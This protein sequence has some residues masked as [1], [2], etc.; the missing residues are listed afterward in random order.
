MNNNFSIDITFE[1]VMLSL[2]NIANDGRIKTGHIK[3][4]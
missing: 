4:I 1:S 2:H 3:C